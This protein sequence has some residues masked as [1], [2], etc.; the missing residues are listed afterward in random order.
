MNLDNHDDDVFSDIQWPSQDT[1]SLLDVERDRP[2]L[3][4]HPGASNSTATPQ[5]PVFSSREWSQTGPLV[6]LQRDEWDTQNSYDDTPPRYIRYDLGWKVTVNTR[7]K[8]GDTT[9]DVVLTPSAHWPLFVEPEVQEALL[10]LQSDGMQLTLSD[11][12]VKVSITKRGQPPFKKHFKKTGVLWGYIEE[13]MLKWEKFVREGKQLKVEVSLNYK[14]ATQELGSSSSRKGNK[15]SAT[16]RQLAVQALQREAEG[17]RGRIW[18]EKYNLFRCEDK[19]CNLHNYCWHDPA[20][21]KHYPLSTFDLTE[22]V[23]RVVKGATVTHEEFP[24][25]MREALYTAEEQKSS[26]KRARTTTALQEKASEAPLPALQI[27]VRPPAQ[28][29]RNK[30]TSPLGIPGYCEDAIDGFVQYMQDKWRNPDR[31]RKFGEMGALLGRKGID[32]DQVYIDQNPNI[33]TDEGID[34]ITANLF[35]RDIPV[36]A[37]HRKH[38]SD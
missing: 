15:G 35:I 24:D 31:K 9:T 38:T 23:D 33:F 37:K 10:N 25:D 7:E 16:Q 14:S 5:G 32:L 22:I 12:N 1:R 30:V 18:R 13:H 19:F 11:I 20:K 3:S 36:Y 21:D 2:Y 4:S 8:V 27:P 28:M 6:L 29:P 17:E 26:R 34:E